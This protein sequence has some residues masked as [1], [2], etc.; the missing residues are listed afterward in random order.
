MEKRRLT[1][2]TKNDLLS[3][4]VWEHWMVDN[5]EFVI[6]SDSKEIHEN[7]NKG[8]IVLTV[9]NLNNGRELIGFCSPQDTSG[10]DYIQPI[11]FTD[12]GQVELWRD[13]DWNN[14]DKDRAFKK[15]G[16]TW[17]DIFPIRF[18]TKVKCDGEFYSGKIFDF[19]KNE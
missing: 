8:Y 4:Q 6:P 12:N 3:N 11:I 7:D 14:D 18:K 9:F 1:N 10:L 17:K 19:N 15:F 16:L 13:N 5:I 2:L